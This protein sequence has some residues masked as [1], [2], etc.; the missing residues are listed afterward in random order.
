[1]KNFFSVA[2]PE[3]VVGLLEIIL[4]WSFNLLHLSTLSLQKVVNYTF[5][6]PTRYWLQLK[7]LLNYVVFCLHLPVALMFE[8]P[9]FPPMS[10]PSGV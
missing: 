6:F 4:L 2:H 7:P 10:I 3:N 1:M 8:I 5:E 9:G